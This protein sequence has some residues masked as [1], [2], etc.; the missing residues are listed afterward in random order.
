MKYVMLWLTHQNW[1]DDNSRMAERGA[2]FATLTPGGTSRRTV[3]GSAA[4]QTISR[5]V[6][7]RRSSRTM[8][9]WW[10]PKPLP[11]KL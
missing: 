2:Y 1:A 4:S 7:R 6:F 11:R 3:S 5:G 9:F 8:Y 10:S